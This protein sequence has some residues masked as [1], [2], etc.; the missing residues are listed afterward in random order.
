MDDSDYLRG[1]Q[2]QPQAV[3]TERAPAEQAP[4]M[5][6]G[7]AT[8]HLG[9]GLIRRKLMR[10]AAARRSAETGTGAGEAFAR[11]TSG[12]HASL[13]HAAEMERAFG[14][15][16]SGV[17]VHVGRE[18]SLSRIDAEA[19]AQGERVAFASA[20]PSREVVAHELTHVVQARQSG[21]AG[22]VRASST[23]L[24]APS[25]AA[26]VEADRVASEVVA[27][28][29]AQVREQVDG[30][31]L[32]RRLI[33]RSELAAVGHRRGSSGSE[34]WNALLDA[35]GAYNEFVEQA[36]VDPDGTDVH[37]R[38]SRVRI[39]A[40]TYLQETSKGDDSPRVEAVNN[41][42]GQISEEC[43]FIDDV[44]ARDDI[45][46]LEGRTWGHCIEMIKH[47]V[48]PQPQLRLDE[49]TT[50]QTNEDEKAQ[51]PVRGKKSDRQEI[52][53]N[54]D[55]RALVEGAGLS[56]NTDTAKKEL[57]ARCPKGPPLAPAEYQAFRSLTN[58]GPEG[59]AWLHAVGL[60]SSDEALEYLAGGDF[61]QFHNLRKAQKVQLASAALRHGY[62]DTPPYYMELSMRGNSDREDS[63]EYKD[64]IRS[65]TSSMWER[66]LDGGQ[67]NEEA[68]QGIRQGGVVDPKSKKALGV[69]ST[70]KRHAQAT[71]ILR[72]VFILLQAG[73]KKW[74]PENEEYVEWE[75]PVATAL[76][77]GG[78]VN[79]RIPKLGRGD[80]GHALTDW[81]GIT[82]GGEMSEDGAVFDR[83]F[84][85]HRIDVGK[86][87]DD[88]RGRFKEKGGMGA[89]ITNKVKGDTKI[90]GMNLTIGGLG[91]RDFN[92]DV[93]LP[94]GAHG[95]MFIGFRPPT[96][97]LDGA[98]QIGIE[99]T[100]PGAKS[101]VGYV[102]DFRSSEKTANPISSVGGLKLDKVGST[103]NPNMVDLQEL[104]GQNED[105]SWLAQL[106]EFE[107]LFDGQTN[108]DL[109]G[110]QQRLPQDG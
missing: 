47:G 97:K 22:G 34:H 13:P 65:N 71:N 95:H 11:A 53:R 98:L 7:M 3:E 24:S 70:M 76:S 100:G 91:T 86:D 17:Q 89:S 9:Q 4:A 45:T 25:D 43:D 50:T 48:A 35:L 87:K 106:D 107:H 58:L 55:V 44:L 101:T 85:T 29:P 104:A 79:I 36:I 75:G 14:Q 57:G 39:T 69:D 52:S 78:R 81:L 18:E 12:G 40:R 68:L 94:D 21:G 63:G 26:E 37:H 15:D 90:L 72:K 8:A 67:V 16:F 99:T 23:V 32:H 103:K 19:A 83:G 66:T 96:R 1:Q 42:M 10:R 102:H 46:S 110:E 61:R 80:E 28:R 31:A 77:H 20:S 5:M 82:Q 59:V 92:G 6:L 51:R 56:P 60:F 73:L 54:E 109:V 38:L 49:V 41:L 105:G 108:R 2:Q 30:P 84:A 93:V 64:Q 33:D 88:E 74:D 62:E 27:G